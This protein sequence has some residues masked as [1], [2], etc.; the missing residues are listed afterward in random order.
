MAIGAFEGDTQK[1]VQAIEPLA[2]QLSMDIPQF[3]RRA[4]DTMVETIRDGASRF[5]DE[6]NSH[7][8]YTIHEMLHPDLVRPDRVILIGG[9]AD[10]LRPY[11]AEAF[12]LDRTYRA[13]GR[14]SRFVA[15]AQAHA[16][17]PTL[18]RLRLYLQTVETALAGRRKVILDRVPKGARRLLYLGRAG[19]WT[20]PPTPAPEP[21]EPIPPAPPQEGSTPR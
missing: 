5:I 9:P 13:D 11:I 16:V 12:G 18:T 14:G 19:L 4:I 8:V 1:A 17:N 21:S 2:G 6:L 10:I 20:I 3:C 15:L 7:P